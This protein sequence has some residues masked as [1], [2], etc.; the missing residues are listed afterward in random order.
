MRTEWRT[1]RAD[2]LLRPAALLAVAVGCIGIA[3]GAQTVAGGLP[4]WFAPLLGTL[5]LAGSAEMLFVGLIAA[6]GTPVVAFAAAA[7][8][9][10][11]HLAYGLAAAPYVGSGAAR[12][13]RIHL[14]NDESIALALAQPD[15]ESGRRGMTYAG[16]GIMLA[17]PLG[18][19]AGAAV[20]SVIAPA[21]LGLDAVFPAVLLALLVPA[22]REKSTR[23]MLLLAILFALVAVP[24]APA[25]LAPILALLAVPA[26]RLFGVR[27]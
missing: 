4:W 22:L 3:Y 27:P 15:V 14:V 11:R 5:V 17:W 24:W 18:A 13:L 19:A 10:A 6:G 12:L 20:G 7:L 1:K 9:N 25:G 23:T 2:P 21:A 26:L 8:V 16:A